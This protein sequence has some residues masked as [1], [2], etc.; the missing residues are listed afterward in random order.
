MP[1][2]TLIKTGSN[3]TG[4]KV[5]TQ[6][7][8]ESSEKLFEITGPKVLEWSYPVAKG[9]NAPGAAVVSEHVEKVKDLLSQTWR[10]GFKTDVK[11]KGVKEMKPLEKLY[12]A[13]SEKS[14]KDE[15]DGFSKIASQK[16]ETIIK[17]EF[18]TFMQG[19]SQKSIKG[20]GTKG[21]TLWC[22]KRPLWKE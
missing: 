5:A 3:A 8:L 2:I 21:S 20:L 10:S 4:I 12:R 22:F 19:V 6:F 7:D 18:D 14:Q 1:T 9:P 11:K 16:A 17:D 13:K 15:R